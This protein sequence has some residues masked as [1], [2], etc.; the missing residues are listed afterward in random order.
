MIIKRK[1]SPYVIW[2]E[3]CQWNLLRMYESW[4]VMEEFLLMIICNIIFYWGNFSIFTLCHSC[5]QRWG[6]RTVFYTPHHHTR[7]SDHFRSS[8]LDI[9][10]MK[11]LCL[12]WWWIS[13]PICIAVKKRALS[14]K[15]NNIILKNCISICSHRKIWIISG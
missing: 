4:Q 2:T 15:K 8:P 7:V 9:A 6:F 14:Y 1:P 10:N 13:F 5:W 3:M 11:I 12:C